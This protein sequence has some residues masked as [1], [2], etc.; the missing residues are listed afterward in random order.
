MAAVGLALLASAVV[1]Y[2]NAQRD[3]PPPAAQTASPPA[4]VTSPDPVP[5]P[6]APPPPEAAAPAE[7]PAARRT[8]PAKRTAAP[9]PA[10]ARDVPAASTGLLTITADVAGAQV[11]LDRQFIGTTPVTAPDVTPG[12]HQ[13]NVS[14]PGY[15]PIVQAIEVA[16]GAGHIAIRF[17]E[18]RLDVAI[19]VVHKHRLGSCR[20][21]LAATPRGLRYETADKDDAFSAGLLELE[22]FQIDYLSKTLRVQPRRG[23]RFDFT[24]PEGNA[25]RLFVFHRDVDKARDQLRKGETP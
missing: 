9:P 19:D 12:S 13:L 1:I 21:R 25:D 8:E 24:D 17:R 20:G 7:R 14:A 10:A 6:A 18:V 4:P 5:A 23:R 22:T 15:D 3:T 2:R 11:F 16:P